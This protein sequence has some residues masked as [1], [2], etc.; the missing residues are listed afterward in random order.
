MTRLRCL[1]CGHALTRDLRWGWL[2]DH[3]PKAQDQVPAVPAGI[4]VT[5][6]DG[7]FSTNPADMLTGALCSTG[8]D[9]GCCGSDG[10]DGPNRA[11]SGCGAIVGTERSDCWTPAVVG[12]L[13]AAVELDALEP[14]D[15]VAA[16]GGLRPFEREALAYA[17]DGDTVQNLLR[18]AARRWPDLSEGSAMRI[19]GGLLDHGLLRIYEDSDRAPRDLDTATLLQ[20]RITAQSY[21]WLEATFSTMARLLPREPHQRL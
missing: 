12:F 13:R 3:D 20:E 2:E 16:A 19:L 17:L 5:L 4:V 10:G 9:V 6:L 15:E 11:C 18:L 1:A 21:T 7:D 8:Y 14:A